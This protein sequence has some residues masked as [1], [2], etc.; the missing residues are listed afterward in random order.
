MV[1]SISSVIF[2]MFFDL[3]GIKISEENNITKTKFKMYHPGGDL[4]KLSNKKLD[5][6]VISCCG[7]GTRLYPITKDIPKF[8][9]NIENRN[10]LKMM[11]DY[12]KEY[13][14]NFIIINDKKYNNIIHFYTFMIIFHLNL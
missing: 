14:D 4:G 2:L 13:T 10:F 9:I 1:P 3:L 8:L 7:K 12:W 6:V 11:I 5:F